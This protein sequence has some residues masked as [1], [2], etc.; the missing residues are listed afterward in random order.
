MGKSRA[1]EIDEDGLAARNRLKGL[2]DFDASNEAGATTTLQ[3]LSTDDALG[4][5][6]FL[7]T[8]S[9]ST[10]L[11]YIA[12]FVG[13]F[14]PTG[15]GQRK[16]RGRPVSHLDIEA[17]R[18]WVIWWYVRQQREL[19]ASQVG[20]MTVAQL[21]EEVRGLPGGVRLFPRTIPSQERLIS[22]VSNGKRKLCIDK[23]WE[24][25]ICE[26]FLPFDR[27]R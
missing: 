20:S 3:A 13:G 11:V 27:N 22:S 23:D 8:A 7:L 4:L 5:P 10:L 17:K 18:A 14:M 6:P 26:K 25:Q 9:R 2:L 24:S 15:A 19:G 12:L 16:A 1:P 21:I